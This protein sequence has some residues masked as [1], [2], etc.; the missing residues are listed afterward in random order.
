LRSFAAAGLLDELHLTLC[1]RIFGG[2]GAPTLT[3]LPGKFL[4]KSTQ[5]HLVA[6]QSAGGECFTRWRVVGG[7]AK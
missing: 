6:M 4:P 7:K 1:P 2:R 5:L 3:G